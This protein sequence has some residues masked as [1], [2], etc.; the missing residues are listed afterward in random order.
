MD[1]S[2]LLQKQKKIFIYK[3]SN[4]RKHTFIRIFTKRYR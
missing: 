3:C 4:E 1:K 2:T